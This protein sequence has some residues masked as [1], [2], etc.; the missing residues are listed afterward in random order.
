[1]TGSSADR[2]AVLA[3]VDLLDDAMSLWKR[4][5]GRPLTR[6]VLQEAPGVSDRKLD[7]VWALTRQ[8][9]YDARALIDGLEAGEVSRFREDKREELRGYLE[10]KG[11][12]AGE[13]PLSAEDALM[14]LQ[15]RHPDAGVS[16]I[17]RVVSVLWR[18]EP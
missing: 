17:E 18:T 1:V 8:K 5:R 15:A 4:G 10:E 11:F 14:E 9:E 2:D 6:D 16:C 3:R 12:I 13:D 7:E